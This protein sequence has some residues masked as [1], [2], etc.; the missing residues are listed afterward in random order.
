MSADEHN[1]KELT[2][3]AFGSS[4][5]ALY[6]TVEGSIKDVGA[7]LGSYGSK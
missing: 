1:A 5:A 7:H 4:T 2:Y 3:L 6:S